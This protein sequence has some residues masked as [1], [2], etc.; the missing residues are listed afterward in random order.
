M[1]EGGGPRLYAVFSGDASNYVRATMQVT[2]STRMMNIELQGTGYT[3][4]QAAR[5]LD[6]MAGGLQEGA[7]AAKS[8][9]SSL[10]EA[11][12]VMSTVASMGQEII[13]MATSLAVWEIRLLQYT[14]QRFIAE[15]RVLRLDRE[16]IRDKQSIIRLDRE[17]NQLTE[18]TITLWNK[19]YQTQLQQTKGFDDLR[20]TTGNALIAVGRF[21]EKSLE[22][23]MATQEWEQEFATWGQKAAYL[24]AP[25][26][27]IMKVH[28]RLATSI[29]TGIIPDF[30]KIGADV[31]WQVDKW[32]ELGTAGMTATDILKSGQEDV[33]GQISNTIDFQHQIT[34]AVA[35]YKSEVEIADRTVLEAIAKQNEAL[36]EQQLMWANI[37]FGVLDVAAKV[38]FLGNILSGGSLF[39]GAGGGG[40]LGLASGA[41]TQS[42]VLP[43]LGPLG[44]AGTV[45]TAEVGFSAMGGPATGATVAGVVAPAALF[46]GSFL[47][48]SKI[49]VETAKWM[50]PQVQTALDKID[51]QMKVETD[52]GKMNQLVQGRQALLD[53]QSTSDIS[54]AIPRA[55]LG[56]LGLG[57]FGI[58]DV[59]ET[60]LYKLEK[61][62]TVLKPSDADAYR[63]VGE[64][65]QSSFGV[66]GGM[67]MRGMSSVAVNPPSNI[68]PTPVLDNNL[69]MTVEQ[70]AAAEEEAV[71]GIVTPTAI[72]ALGSFTEGKAGS[73]PIHISIGDIK[74]YPKEFSKKEDVRT[75]ALELR[76]YLQVEM[77]RAQP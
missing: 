68:E 62:E 9:G 7:Q 24:G 11:V 57:Q 66:T 70:G 5:A 21:G 10:S 27:T 30:E 32:G 3:A 4:A 54:L 25:L 67:A 8:Y 76:R 18:K 6:T 63:S 39:G 19:F 69:R 73:G 15:Q 29:E 40:L 56:F 51:A 20:I 72:A 65:P 17:G 31:G 74:I 16:L 2:G 41:L 45:E 1:A 47:A 35:D 26:E 50:D 36:R 77:A 53:Y 75:F 23:R 52:P 13:S 60:G 59:P 38:L 58:P 42:A 37:V 33:A 43:C 61:H 34:K 48:G 46:A 55:I 49:G 71:A 28:E 64:S 44:A 12:T 22:A 14:N